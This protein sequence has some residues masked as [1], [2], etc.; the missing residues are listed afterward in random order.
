[1]D[2]P[3]P[4]DRKK[5]PNWVIE[6]PMFIVF[7]SIWA[8]ALI[9]YEDSHLSQIISYLWVIAGFIL[10]FIVIISFYGFFSTLIKK[11]DR[12]R[13]IDEKERPI[14]DLSQS[15]FIILFLVLTF[16]IIILLAFATLF[17][18]LLVIGGHMLISWIVVSQKWAA[19]FL[20]ALIFGKMV[21]FIVKGVRM[22]L[23]TRLNRFLYN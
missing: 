17:S 16:I 1:M 3:S 13:N 18:V 8:L 14:K 7:L 15:E 12:T 10:A 22:A 4:P 6:L 11:E 23:L 19:G 20:I 5:L 2:N 21:E 9:F